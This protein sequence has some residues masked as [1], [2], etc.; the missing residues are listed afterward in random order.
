M[1]IENTHFKCLK[2]YYRDLRVEVTHLFLECSYQ[3]EKNNHLSSFTARLSH[4]SRWSI[5]WKAPDCQV[6][7]RFWL[8]IL[9]PGFVTHHDVVD[10]FRF[11]IFKFL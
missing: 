7:F 11:S 3:E 10:I 4:L 9:E 8:I 6:S 2:N 1:C 5:V